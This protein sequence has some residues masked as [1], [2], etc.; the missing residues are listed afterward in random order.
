MQAHHYL[1][2]DH[3][4]GLFAE[5]LT[6][7]RAHVTDPNALRGVQQGM[8]D[9]L[10]DEKTASLIVTLSRKQECPS[11]AGRHVSSCDRVAP[12]WACRP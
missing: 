1:Q 9:L 12:E 3:A 10:G 7:A 4:L 11:D 6:I 2:T 8:T 5:L